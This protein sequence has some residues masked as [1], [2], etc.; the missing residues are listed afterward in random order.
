MKKYDSCLKVLTITL[1]L[2]IQMLTQ[3][4]CVGN[5]K[6]IQKLYIVVALGIDLNSD[7]RYE[8]TMQVLNPSSTPNQTSDSRGT[9]GSSSDVLI[10]SG[11]GDSFYDAVF[12][13]SKTM[14][15]VQHFGHLKY[16][17]IGEALAQGEQEFLTDSLIRNE[18]IRLNTPLL[19]TKGRASEIVSAKTNEG[20]IPAI[21]VDDLSQRQV[22][23]GYR[24]FTYLLDIINSLGSKTTAP[25]LGVIELVKPEDKLG[26]E[27][28][29]L[30]GTAVFKKSKLIGYLNDRETRG[31]SWINGKIEVGNITLTCPT[32]GKVSLEI[33][34]ASSKIKPVV[35]ES[36]VSLEIKIKTSSVV[37]AINNPTDPVKEPEIMDEIGRAANKAVEE[38]VKLALAA[39]RDN[40]GADIFGFGEKVHASYPKEWSNMEKD[41]DSIYRDMNIKV[42]V[43][44]KIRST[45][46]I[47]KSVH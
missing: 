1:I 16:I 33:L 6:Q 3:T 5:K 41:W 35:D 37:R 25:V 32:L 45:G 34:R 46:S 13:A 18:E 31:F 7:G 21:V 27:T 47:L 24:P 8:V 19:I 10:Y 23:I 9:T 26:S 2:I 30:S 17:V 39:A 15:K 42:V 20:L 12:E 38:E 28:F 22:I 14:S 36:S 4:A 40:L 43:E 11:K 29:K 44:S